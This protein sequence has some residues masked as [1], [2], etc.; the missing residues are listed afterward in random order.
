MLSVVTIALGLQLPSSSQRP[1][2]S[3]AL[4][5]RGVLTQA[6]SALVAMPLAA[7]VPLAASADVR[8]AN[9]GIARN[10]KDVNRLLASQGFPTLKVPSGMSPLIGYVGAASPANIDGSKSKERAFT[11]CLLV[12]F[13]Y[14]SGWL[15]EYPNID[16]NGESGVI[17]ANNYVKG[18]SCNFA[19]YPLEKDK[20]IGDVSKET[21]KNLLIAQM[22]NDVFEDVKIKK[23]KAV[24]QDDGTEMAL[25]DF[26]YTL[27]TRAGFTVI[28]QGLASATVTDNTL[29]GLV[30]A[31]TEGRYKELEPL[32]RQSVASFRA[33]PVKAPG[34]TL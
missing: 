2:V 23:A 29:V 30:S 32:L 22:S 6:T 5:R 9:Q 1:H 24:T 18:D 21:L 34:F 3:E 8:G 25:I 7:Q 11:S 27:L 12:R 15:A 31:T 33:Y 10:E 14:P 13:V 20:K 28:R 17:G 16:E 4:S 19:A 26:T